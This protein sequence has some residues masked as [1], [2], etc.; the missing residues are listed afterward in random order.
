MGYMDNKKNK[1]ML[2]ITNG[3]SANEISA[4]TGVSSSTIWRHKKDMSFTAEEVIAIARAYHADPIAGLVAF[5]YLTE[6][7]VGMPLER[8][9]TA[10]SAVGNETLLRELTRRLGERT[11]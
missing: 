9:R 10:L 1:W 3:A 2:L 8:E 4:K 6:Q 11:D 5:G 7:E